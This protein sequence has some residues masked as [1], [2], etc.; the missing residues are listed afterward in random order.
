MELA[1]RQM[2]TL[3][4]PGTLESLKPSPRPVQPPPRVHVDPRVLREVAPPILPAP[5][6]SPQPERPVRELPNAP[7]PNPND[8]SPDPQPSAPTPK[9]EAPNPALKLEAPDTPQPQHGLILPKSSTS[10]SL[11]DTIR[12]STKSPSAGGRSGAWI[13]PIPRTGWLPGTDGAQA[14]RSTY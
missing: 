9:T 12:E 6:P 4:P 7:A 10:R 3:L 14:C 8:I 2:V 11:Q 1:R 5:A 13:C